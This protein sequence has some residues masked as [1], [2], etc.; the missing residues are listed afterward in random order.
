MVIL[1]FDIRE[2]KESS[3]SISRK[4]LRTKVTPDFHQWGKSGV[5]IKMIKM[6]IFQYFSIKSYFVDVY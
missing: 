5:G 4:H 3:L 2:P 1:V 6:D